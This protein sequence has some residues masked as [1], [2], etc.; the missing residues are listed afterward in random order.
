MVRLVAL[1]GIVP[2]ASPGVGTSNRSKLTQIASWPD[3]LFR[4]KQTWDPLATRVSMNDQS[5]PIS[6]PWRRFLRV[7]RAGADHSCVGDRCFAGLDCPKRSDSARC[8]GG[9][10]ESWRHRFL[11]LGFARWARVSVGETYCER[12]AC[13]SRWNRLFR[14]RHRGGT[15]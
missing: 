5:K 10:R 4:A 7:Q 12:L 14:P 9:D 13:G 6:R 8:R 3:I 2:V 11:R 1:P 15:K